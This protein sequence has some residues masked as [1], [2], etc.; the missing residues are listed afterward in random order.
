MKM[1]FGQLQNNP[2]RRQKREPSRSKVPV[3]I[4]PPWVIPLI[5]KDHPDNKKPP[6]E[7]RPAIE[8]PLDESI[9]PESEM[10]GPDERDRGV[11]IIDLRA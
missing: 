1:H 6:K 4:P 8:L 3:R 11:V 7:D 2:G 5:D 9:P 10:P